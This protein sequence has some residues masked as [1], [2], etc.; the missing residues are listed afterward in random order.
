MSDG[1]TNTTLEQLFLSREFGGAATASEPTGADATEAPAWNEGTDTPV[2]AQLDQVF[3][4]PHFGRISANAGVPVG[5][6]LDHLRPEA[7]V[8]AFTPAGPL[9]RHRVVAAISGVAAAALVV[10]GVTSGTL[11][12]HGHP[13]GSGPGQQALASGGGSVSKSVSGPAA[14][15][16]VGAT[17]SSSGPSAGAGVGTSTRTGMVVAD[18]AAGDRSAAPAV[19]V[20]TSAPPP[21]TMTPTPAVEPD[22]VSASTSVVAPTATGSAPAPTP[23]PTPTPNVETSAVSS[24]VTVVVG[25][26]TTAGNN[27]T[28]TSAQLGAAIPAAAPLTGLLGDVGS[29]VSGLGKGLNSATR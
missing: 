15:S 13:A 9:T 6:D 12:P 20:D 26:T 21:A 16:S 22:S 23:A 28:T 3:L 1:G 10:V 17:G 14:G 11:H 8:L 24:V 19:L 29:S 25:V 27:I 2:P 7:T 5:V 18:G 4:S